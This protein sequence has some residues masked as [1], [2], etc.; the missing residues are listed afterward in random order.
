MTVKP[1]KMALSKPLNSEVLGPHPAQGNFATGN[2]SALG[3]APL[4]LLAHPEEP[5]L[6]QGL[7]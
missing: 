5:A 4:R 7:C 1:E 6:C 3:K 2:A